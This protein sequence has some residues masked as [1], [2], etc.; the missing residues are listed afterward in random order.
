MRMIPNRIANV[1]VDAN[2]DEYVEVSLPLLGPNV[3]ARLSTSWFNPF[4]PTGGNIISTSPWVA[5]LTNEI[6]KNYDVELP[7]Q[8]EEYIL[9]FGVQQNSLT[10]L[11]P[12]TIRRASQAFS[13]WKNDNNSTLQKDIAMISENKLFEFQQ[14]N[15]RQPNVSELQEIQ[16]KTALEAKGLAVIRFIGSG[17]LPQQPRYVSPL[18]TYSDKLRKYQEQYG[19]SDGTDKFLEDFPDYW[20]VV[21]KLT[22]PTSGLYPDRTAVNLIKKNKIGRAHV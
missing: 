11:T 10:P 2:G 21:D 15:H 1:Q 18:Q 17:L 8:L 3:K 6:L 4:N 20:L 14:N 12:T 19:G 16:N 9:P 5:S 22:D 13:A 7:K